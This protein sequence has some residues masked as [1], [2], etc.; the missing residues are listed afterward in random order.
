MLGFE[1]GRSERTKVSARHGEILRHFV[2]HI[3]R[4]DG[5][6]HERCE[7]HLWYLS[8]VFGEVFSMYVLLDHRSSGTVVPE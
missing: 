1:R 5:G 7:R 8:A 3:M 2:S 4:G 6:R